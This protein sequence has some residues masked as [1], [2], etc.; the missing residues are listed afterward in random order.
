MVEAFGVLVKGSDPTFD[1][2]LLD[3][4]KTVNVASFRSGVVDSKN[5]NDGSIGE[6]VNYMENI[7][8]HIGQH[9][10]AKQREPTEK[11]S[12]MYDYNV[13]LMSELG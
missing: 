6:F 5:Q 7:D 4:P 8:L 2:T 13:Y 3:F 11:Q 1:E 12:N 9:I 10:L